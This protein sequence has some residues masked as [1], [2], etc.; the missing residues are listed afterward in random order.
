MQN[1]YN[2][3]ASYSWTPPP[4][5]LLLSHIHT[6][7]C[8]RLNIAL[9]ESSCFWKSK[10]KKKNIFKILKSNRISYMANEHSERNVINLVLT[11]M[12]TSISLLCYCVVELVQTYYTESMMPS[13]QHFCHFFV[14]SKVSMKVVH[15][16]VDFMSINDIWIKFL[17]D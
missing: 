11:D 17:I 15:N 1:K 9:M 8:A 10:K 2:F 5:T 14:H 4:S 3:H 12:L 6:N 13:N 7:M 16:I